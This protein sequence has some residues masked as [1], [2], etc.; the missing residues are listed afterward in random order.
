MSPRHEQLGGKRVRLLFLR[1]TWVGIGMAHQVP[2][3][4]CRVESATRRIPFV[5][6]EDYDGPYTLGMAECVNAP[7]HNFK[8]GYQDSVRLHMPY[9]V[10]NWP[11]R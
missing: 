10:T 9:Q 4:V 8:P 2:E 7:V 1:P 3:F 11:I 6:T 5:A